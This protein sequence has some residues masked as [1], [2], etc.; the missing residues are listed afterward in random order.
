M[1]REAI[2]PPRPAA[3]LPGGSPPA[4]SH[5]PS[6][7]PARPHTLTPCARPCPHV[8][9]AALGGLQSSFASYEG[10]LVGWQRA[11]L[12]AD[13]STFRARKVIVSSS[14]SPWTLREVRVR[15]L[16]GS[17]APRSWGAAEERTDLERLTPLPSQGDSGPPPAAVCCRASAPHA[18]LAPLS[19]PSV[20]RLFPGIPH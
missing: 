3:R 10:H 16:E 11:N 5:R 7:C 19:H 18:G 1:A 9:T 20:F 6:P 13:R 2:Q 8:A 14:P 12:K 15:Q 17:A 4:R